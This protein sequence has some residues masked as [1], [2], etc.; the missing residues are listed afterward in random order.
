MGEQ[1]M[2]FEQENKR[3]WCFKK[4]KGSKQ[5]SVFLG[6]VGFEPT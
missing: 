3:S 1:E 6:E 2:V 4:D 5:P